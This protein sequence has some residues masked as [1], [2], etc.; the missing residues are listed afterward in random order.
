V[1]LL[2]LRWYFSSS[3]WVRVLGNILNNGRTSLLVRFPI[4]AMIRFGKDKAYIDS[5]IMERHLKMK[6]IAN[7]GK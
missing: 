6:K 2:V 1:N 4:I 5:S 7:K 3:S